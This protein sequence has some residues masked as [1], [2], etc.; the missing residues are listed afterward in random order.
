MNDDDIR[1]TRHEHG[2]NRGCRTESEADMG[3]RPNDDGVSGR[4]RVHADG[5]ESGPWNVRDGG[6]LETALADVLREATLDPEAERQALAAFRAAREADGHQAR[7][8]RRDDWRPPAERR[9]GRRVKATFGAV[10]ASIALGGVA[11]AAI[12][13]V[14]SHT[15][16]A[17]RGT[18][19]PSA[20]ASHRLG[21][22]AAPSGGLGPTKRPATAKD[23][24]A[25]CRAYEQV[26]DRGKAL[27]A[28]AWQRLVAAAGGT[29]N[30]AAY[31]AD[32]LTHTTVAPS[33]P[34][35]TG[36]PGV[37]AADPGKGAA[38]NSGASGNNRSGAGD[39]AGKSGE[40]N[41]GKHKQ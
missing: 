4:R 10:F 34:G 1:Q 36:R 33:K 39:A 29:D 23:T 20:V 5:T 24:K 22:S 3:E 18:A 38:G 19:P 28:T 35:G 11:V 9:A 14:G 26:K 12:G 6:A 32:Q 25:H 2:M 21:A 41:S 31:C 40:K 8:R 17:G 16:D 7:T 13:S 15:D 27:E 37:G 30:V